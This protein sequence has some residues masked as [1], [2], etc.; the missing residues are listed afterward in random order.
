MACRSS[1]REPSTERAKESSPDARQRDVVRG[2]SVCKVSTADD[3]PLG[4]DAPGVY[5]CTFGDT[6]EPPAAQPEPSFRRACG[7]PHQFNRKIETD[8][9]DRGPYHHAVRLDRSYFELQAKFAARIAEIEGLNLGEAYRLH[10]AFYALARDNDAGVPPERNDFDPT[11]PAWV[12][13]LEA[14]DSGADAVEYVY[15]AYI[16]GDAREEDQATTCFAFDYWPD[17]RLVRIHFS[18]DQRGNA[19]RPASV[20]DRRRE[21]TSIFQ[22]IALEHADAQVVR[23]T[24]WLYHL[25]AYRRHFPPSFIDSLESAGHPHQFAAL[26]CQFID[27]F[28][29]VKPALAQPF[30]AEVDRAADLHQLDAAFPLGDC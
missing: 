5:G 14:L 19:L 8:L 25:H 28:G 16:D 3:R 21:L 11:H 15:Q 20:A 24:S 9:V 18:N 7:A 6:P 1:R 27:R 17:D 26:W 10:T 13:F 2:Q 30:V 29:V 4:D 12:A 23:G 22:T